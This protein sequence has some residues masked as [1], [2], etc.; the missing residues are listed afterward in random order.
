[1]REY[2]LATERQRS[3]YYEPFSQ[4]NKQSNQVNMKANNDLNMEAVDM[5]EVQR[6]AALE[7]VSNGDFITRAIRAYSV[8]T[9]ARH[10][11][12]PLLKPEPW[13]EFRAGADG[14]VSFRVRVPFNLFAQ[15]AMIEDDV[16]RGSGGKN[17]Q[18][19]CTIAEQRLLES[20][21]ELECPLEV[22][23]RCIRKM[24]E[25]AALRE[26]FESMGA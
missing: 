17:E 23:E 16:R 15:L 8:Q 26:E 14:A 24:Q 1:M 25:L 11:A 3:V 7:G 4:I 9:L 2:W 5:A 13:R 20:L 19:V 6:A 12:I 22:Y 18:D 21:H 10:N